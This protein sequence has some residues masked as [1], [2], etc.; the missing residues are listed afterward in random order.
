MAGRGLLDN[1]EIEISCSRGH[2]VKKRIG[3]IRRSPTFRC[4]VCGQAIEVD[5]ATFDRELRK[6]DREFEALQR[7]LK[8]FGR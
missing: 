6:V 5:A 7:S 1:N 2:R 8:N 4:P 3:E